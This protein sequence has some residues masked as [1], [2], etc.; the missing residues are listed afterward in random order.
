MRFKRQILKGSE[1][2]CYGA[3]DIIDWHLK[4]HISTEYLITDT[5]K[6]SYNLTFSSFYVFRKILK[7]YIFVCTWYKIFKKKKVS[8]LIM[9]NFS[10]FLCEI[11]MITRAC[12]GSY[13]LSHLLHSCS[14][15]CPTSS[16][17]AWMLIEWYLSGGW[18]VF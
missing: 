1:A 3:S 6:K 15:S 9:Q 13:H 4:I 11:K 18:L 7:K 17:L 12:S 14:P 16:T 2:F 8:Y 5:W 10:K